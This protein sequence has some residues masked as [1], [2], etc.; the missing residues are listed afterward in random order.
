[1]KLALNN[2]TNVYVKS[3][4]GANTEDMYSYTKPTS[5]R[6]P[7]LIILHCGTNDLRNEISSERI[8]DNIVTLARSL[9]T[10]ATDIIVS[11]ITPRN[12]NLDMKGREV[13]K[14]LCRKLSGQ[15]LGYIDNTNIDVNQHLNKSGLHLN[16]LGVK[17]LADNY[18]DIIDL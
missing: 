1:M 17:T 4:P 14:L 9:K 10:E 3:F 2:T 18:L 5:K 6:N 7:N 12:D 8:A 15:N 11:G 13:N 16:Y